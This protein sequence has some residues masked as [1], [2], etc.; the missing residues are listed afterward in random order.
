[1]TKR[2]IGVAAIAILVMGVGAW[3]LGMFHRVDPQV[4][5]LEQM[6]TQMFANRDVPQAERRQQFGEMR[7]RMESLTEEQRRQFWENGR[8]QFM[9]FAEQRMDE[10]FAL[11]PEDQQKRL[12]EII[13]RML[14]RRKEREQNPQAD[15]NRRGGGGRQ[16]WQNMTDAQRDAARKQRL[17]RTSPELR[18]GF[19]EFR[20][21]MNDRLE[22]RGL[23]PD[24]FGGGFRGM[25]R[26]A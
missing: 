8:E 22:A 11:S 13:D 24:Q 2:R 20:R 3:A 26:G 14:E 4:A 5:E 25:G 19:S 17:D 1:M 9:Q 18:A 15:G 23:P 10:F 21:M 6:R 12:D 7:Q 16:G